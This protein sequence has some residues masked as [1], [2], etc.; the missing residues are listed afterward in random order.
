MFSRFSRPRK[1]SDFWAKHGKHRVSSF[2]N[3]HSSPIFLGSDLTR[4]D[5]P[6]DPKGGGTW[7]NPPPQVSDDEDD[8]DDDDDEDDDNDDD[9]ADDDDVCMDI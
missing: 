5:Q 2:L 3:L 9:D 4:Y 7:T 1:S 8:D 6:E